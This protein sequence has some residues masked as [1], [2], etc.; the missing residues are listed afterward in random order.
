MCTCKEGSIWSVDQTY[1]H[2]AHWESTE[3][4]PKIEELHEYF[5]KLTDKL[6]E[7]SIF[8][9]DS[10]SLLDVMPQLVTR[11]CELLYN[12]KS[13]QT[14]IDEIGDPNSL[15]SR[16]LGGWGLQAEMKLGVANDPCAGF[17]VGG[18]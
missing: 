8:V 10:D 12:K 17:G 5:S 14:M 16:F 18:Y 7:D 11:E 1:C 3:T 9:K 4:D 15:K 13:N 6:I 2:P